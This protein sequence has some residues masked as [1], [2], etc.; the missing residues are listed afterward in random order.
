MSIF[1]ALVIAETSAQATCSTPPQDNIDNPI[2]NGIVV[3][4]ICPARECLS[5]RL[6]T[7]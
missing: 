4:T 1:L 7:I 2:R 6:F 5:A 3:L